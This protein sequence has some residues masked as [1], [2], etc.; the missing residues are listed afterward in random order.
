MKIQKRNIFKDTK[1][2]DFLDI[3][4]HEYLNLYPIQ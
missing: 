4:I 3:F 1:Y 2:M